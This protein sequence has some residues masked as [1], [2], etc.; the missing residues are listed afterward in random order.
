MAELAGKV[1]VINTGSIAG[2]IAGRGPIVCS[3]AKAAVIHMTKAAA[4]PL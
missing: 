1:G 2:V 4:M 3:A